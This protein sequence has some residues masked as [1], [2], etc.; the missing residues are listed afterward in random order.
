MAAKKESAVQPCWRKRNFNRAFSRDWRR[1]SLSR[2]TSAMARATG[3]TWSRWMKA[4]SFTARW[5]SVERPPAMRR[6][7]PTSELEGKEVKE[8]EEVTEEEAVDGRDCANRSG[9]APGLKA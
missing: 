3:M 6:E 9:K 1:T 4:F 7:K 5:G 2:K 8:V